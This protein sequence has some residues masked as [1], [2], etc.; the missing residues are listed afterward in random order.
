MYISYTAPHDPRE[1]PEN[2]RA[3]YDP[4]AIPLPANF[5]PEHPFDNGELKIRDELLETIY[6]LLQQL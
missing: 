1:M 3:M 6:L 4:D 2:Y 5:L